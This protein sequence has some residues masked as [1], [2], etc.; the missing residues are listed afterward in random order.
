MKKPSICIDNVENQTFFVILPLHSV[1][2]A[3]HIA[4]LLHNHHR[5][6]YE[7]HR[8]LELPRFRAQ[9]SRIS[10]WFVVNR[11]AYGD[12]LRF[13][14]MYKLVQHEGRSINE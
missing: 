10:M 7:Q 5:K 9:I 1:K 3:R 12:S 8:L 13:S 2:S 4:R 11:A 14:Y 6:C